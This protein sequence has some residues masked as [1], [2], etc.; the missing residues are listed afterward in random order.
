MGTPVVVHDRDTPTN[1][2]KVNAD[3]SLNAS[4]TPPTGASATQ[5]QGAG[6]SGA[7]AVGSPILNGGLFTTNAN[8]PAVTTGQTISLQTDP[9]GNL[10][11]AP[12]RPAAADIVAGS[13]THTATTGATTFATIPAGR[14]CVGWVI[15]ACAVGVAAAAT[16]AG[17]ALGIVSTAGTGVSPAAGNYLP[18]EARA[19]ANAATGTTGSSGANND[20]MQVTITAPVGNAVQLQGTS[21]IAG[22]NG[23]VDYA[24]WGVL[25]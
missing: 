17:Q 5:V 18:C 2:L 6:A 7:T 12:Q 16:T 9:A 13:L 4:S 23:R 1:A 25:Q 19:G 20:G 21:T 8:Q 10:R 3:G 11:V 15:V 14:T 22:T 24:F